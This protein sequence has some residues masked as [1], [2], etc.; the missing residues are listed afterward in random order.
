MN[1]KTRFLGISLL[2]TGI[3]LIYL[4]L[5]SLILVGCQNLSIF[6]NRFH[7]LLTNIK[8][9]LYQHTAVFNLIPKALKKAWLALFIFANK[10]AYFISDHVA[11]MFQPS[12]LI[13]A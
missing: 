10:I 9:V 8:I 5:C 13:K 1:S 12:L 11:Y 4:R 7:K 6:F 2:Y 3:S